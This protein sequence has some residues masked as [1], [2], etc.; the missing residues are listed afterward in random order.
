[1]SMEFGASDPVNWTMV[2]AWAN[3]TLGR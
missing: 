1:L 2:E 3:V